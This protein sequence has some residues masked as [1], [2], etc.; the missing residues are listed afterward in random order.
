MGY[1]IYTKSQKQV[2]NIEKGLLKR[3]YIKNDYSLVFPKE[4]IIGIY[5]YDG[6]I[7]DLSYGYL[8]EDMCT[9]DPRTSW[10]LNREQCLTE[11]EFFKKV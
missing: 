9:T 8:C 1:Y 4:E 3:G 2:E 11:E 10:I 5:T 6:G 7:L